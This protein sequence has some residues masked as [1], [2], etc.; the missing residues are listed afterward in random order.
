MREFLPE[1]RVTN[2][3]RSSTVEATVMGPF[4][5]KRKQPDTTPPSTFSIPVA[6]HRECFLYLSKFAS[7]VERACA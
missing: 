3:L 1:E 4:T 6:P 2:P 5:L 7:R